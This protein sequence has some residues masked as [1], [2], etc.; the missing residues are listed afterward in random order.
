M[1]LVNGGVCPTV[2]A[3][4]ED[5]FEEPPLGEVIY[6]RWHEEVQRRVWNGSLEQEL[7]PTNTLIRFD[8]R[9]WHRGSTALSSGWRFFVRASRYYA[10]D[11]ASAPRGNPRTNEVRRQVQVYLENA[12]VGW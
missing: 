6:S 9:T 7:V 11:G 10:P 2:F 12:N 1:A 8:D 3:L 5:E 4:G